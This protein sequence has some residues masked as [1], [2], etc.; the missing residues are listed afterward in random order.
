MMRRIFAFLLILLGTAAAQNLGKVPFKTGV[1]IQ[2][3]NSIAV[4]QIFPGRYGFSSLGGVE[5]WQWFDSV[6]TATVMATNLNFTNLVSNDS[7]TYFQMDRVTM[8]TD[9][10]LQVNTIIPGRYGFSK[11]GSDVSR[12]DFGY[13]GRID[14]RTTRTD[15][16]STDKMRLASNGYK[17]ETV[18]GPPRE[19]YNPD[20]LIPETNTTYYS[21]DYP[22]ALPRGGANMGTGANW[23]VMASAK[24]VGVLL[25]IADTFKER[26]A[27][28]LMQSAARTGATLTFFVN[29][30]LLQPEFRE[31]YRDDGWDNTMAQIQAAVAAGHELGDHG[32]YDTHL[33]WR[34]KPT[35]TESDWGVRK[36][37]GDTTWIEMALDTTGYTVATKATKPLNVRSGNQFISQTSGAFNGLNYDWF[38]LFYNGDTLIVQQLLNEESGNP[39]T[40]IVQNQYLQ[41]IAGYPNADD[42]TYSLASDKAWLTT[43]PGMRRLFQASKD[44]FARAGLPRPTTYQQA[45]GRYGDPHPDS[46]SIAAR[47]EGYTYVNVFYNEDEVGL[48]YN[49]TRT[50]PEYSRSTT[51][52][53]ET[54]KFSEAWPLIISNFALRKLAVQS[55]HGNFAWPGSAMQA[56]YD[57]LFAAC[58][59]YGIPVLSNRDWGIM[60]LKSHPNPFENIFPPLQNDW[61][62]DGEPD[63]IVRGASTTYSSSGGMAESAGYRISRSSVGD[64]VA[65]NYLASVDKG[66]NILTI[67]T[68]GASGDVIGID[69]TGGGYGSLLSTT[70]TAE[71][72]TW[73]EH[74]I[75]FDVPYTV[76]AILIDIDCDTYVS[77]P[78]EISGMQ[79]RKK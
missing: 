51:F 3:G 52:D 32:P 75:E 77:G 13:F 9:G 2:K 65:V 58:A 40:L 6:R 67:F 21:A 76:S 10:F 28:T 30:G 54:Q 70:I 78:V 5:T 26:E 53:L 68:K 16:L 15:S 17:I 29:A 66:R 55:N 36:I 11:I 69:I 25:R 60:L 38:T 18:G 42:V 39:D 71:T 35:L 64:L 31:Q 37:T 48:G 34:G 57:S 27:A 74:L 22:F 20:G 1:S 49:D 14:G 8:Q 45:G 23:G 46:A 4:Q 7:R 62:G 79:L 12:L 56:R 72:G 33:Y 43:V 47:M 50:N 44:A 24:R 61:D 73:E 41:P 19:T 59:E 63:G